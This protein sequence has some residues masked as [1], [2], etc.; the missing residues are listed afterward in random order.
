MGVPTILYISN[1]GNKEVVKRFENERTPEKLMEWTFKNL[2]NSINLHKKRLG[3]KTAKRKHKNFKR[4]KKISR[5]LRNTIKN[6]T[7]KRKGRR[8]KIRI[9]SPIIY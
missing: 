7:K 9:G 2:K 4:S 1:T 8:H 3:K 6:L 5:S